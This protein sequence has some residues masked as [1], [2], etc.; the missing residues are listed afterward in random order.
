MADPER[1][2]GFHRRREREMNVAKSKEQ[3]RRCPT[4]RQ[5]DSRVREHKMPDGSVV[6]WH[7]NVLGCENAERSCSEV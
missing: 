3:D 4:C 6:L 1:T 2:A 5:R 7:C